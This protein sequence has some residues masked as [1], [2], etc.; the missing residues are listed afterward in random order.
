ME[1][2]AYLLRSALIMAL[3]GAFVFLCIVIV[4]SILQQLLSSRFI[5]IPEALK[6]LL[7]PSS[8]P[9]RLENSFWLSMGTVTLV[10]LTVVVAIFISDVIDALWDL[11]LAI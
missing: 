2:V 5:H 10:I 11:F 7:A 6:P 8:G 9:T 4:R 1:G 3:A